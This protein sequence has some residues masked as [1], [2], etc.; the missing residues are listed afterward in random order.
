MFCLAAPLP[1]QAR[2]H[3][4]PPSHHQEPQSHPSMV[5]MQ[6]HDAAATRG[7]ALTASSR[8]SSPRARTP[9]TAAVNADS[10]PDSA[11]ER[12]PSLSY[13]HHRNTSIVHG[14]QHSRTTSY[15][16]SPTTSPLSPQ[17]ISATGVDVA[18][19]I[20]GTMGL[21]ETLGLKGRNPKDQRPTQAPPTSNPT[22]RDD[23]SGGSTTPTQRSV[24]LR[25]KAD[26]HSRSKSKIQQQ[27]LKTVGEYA[28]HHLFNAFVGQAEEKI[29]KTIGDPTKPEN[30]VEPICGYGVDPAFDQVIS[31]L[32]HIARQKP[33]PLVD[34]LMYWRKHKSEDVQAARAEFASWQVRNFLTLCRRQK[35]HVHRPFEHLRNRRPHL[36]SAFRVA[37][38]NRLAATR[39]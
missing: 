14:I 31:A 25:S 10:S 11:L 36:S 32:G 4:G 24:S 23:I 20:D 19:A 35:A 5:P 16:N 22:L 3:A 27:D 26:S 15:V 21:L 6:S 17:T 7:R 37:I 9:T 8:A 12:K 33:K 13:G 34:T 30:K 29:T 18:E 38:Q 2:Q 1:S 28:L 39:I